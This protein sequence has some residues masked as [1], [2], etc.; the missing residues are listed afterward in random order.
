M[1]T[2]RAQF[3]FATCLAKPSVPV[4]AGATKATTTSGSYDVKDIE[5]DVVEI[6]TLGGQ[7]KFN[8]EDV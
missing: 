4:A 6:P 5:K 2:I 8:Y 1:P 7:E 3:T